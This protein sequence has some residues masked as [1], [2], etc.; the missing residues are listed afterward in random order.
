MSLFG[1]HMYDDVFEANLL[2]K[3][4]TDSSKPSKDFSQPLKGR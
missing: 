3:T 1:D 4:V 2:T